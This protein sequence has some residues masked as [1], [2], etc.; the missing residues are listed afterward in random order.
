MRRICLFCAVATFVVAI[1]QSAAAATISVLP[2]LPLNRT[3]DN[4]PTYISTTAEPATYTKPDN[5]LIDFLRTEDPRDLDTRGVNNPRNN[6]H[7]FTIN[8]AEFP[9]GIDL[10]AIAFNFE[11]RGS[12]ATPAD[13]F[14]FR[15]FRVA[16][17]NAFANLVEP[18][19]ADVLASGTGLALPT[20]MEL[21]VTLPAANINANA[22]SRASATAML[23]FDVALHLEPGVYGFQFTPDWNAQTANYTSFQ[24]NRSPVENLG[25]IRWENGN[26]GGATPNAGSSYA[27]G[28]VGTVAVPEPAS[29][30]LF[31]LAGASVALLRRRK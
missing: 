30:M 6:G 31:G 1:G 13:T 12:A 27:F 22:N 5:L 14:A 17:G 15:V 26:A 2:P 24:L 28:L 3:S 4:M 18:A 7:S 19:P 20:S 9:N 23:G 11:G 25:G 8:A 10:N 29:V 16:S 21:G